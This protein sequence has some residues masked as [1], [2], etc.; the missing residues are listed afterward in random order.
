LSDLPRKNCWTIAEWVGGWGDSGRDAA[1]PRS[2][3]LDP[4]RCHAAG[5]AEQTSFATKP[6]LAARMAARFLDAGHRAAWV[7][8]DERQRRRP[9]S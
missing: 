2:W 4:G 9:A 6:A 1:P 5:L 7:A 8:G 3:T